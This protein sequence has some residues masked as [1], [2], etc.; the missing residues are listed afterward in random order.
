MRYIISESVTEPAR[1]NPSRSP[2]AGLSASD[3]APR[4]E[5]QSV[6][7]RICRRRQ[8]AGPRRHLGR[9]R[10]RRRARRRSAD[11]PTPPPPPMGSGDPDSDDGAARK[12]CAARRLS[13]GRRGPAPRVQAAA[14]LRRG[15][16]ASAARPRQ[17]AP[18]CPPVK[19]NASR[20]RL[21]SLS[22][23]PSRRTAG[24][25][26]SESPDR[27]RRTG[28]PAAEAADYRSNL[29]AV[30]MRRPVHWNDRGTPRRGA[31]VFDP[32]APRTGRRGA[33]RLGAM[34]LSGPVDWNDQMQPLQ[35]RRVRAKPPCPG[36]P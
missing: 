13:S 32:A 29:A 36:R 15:A 12:F 9:T 34:N 24:G 6:A 20:D 1:Q 5:G 35:A 28:P 22:L 18:P 19:A 23:S 8:A 11:A 10:C 14:I 3:P 27:R 25:R 17:A 21:S 2:R 26:P 33:G 16:A 31:A 7:G 4:T 30:L